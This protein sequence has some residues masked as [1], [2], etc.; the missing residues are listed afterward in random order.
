METDCRCRH[1]TVEEAL[2]HAV[3]N[4]GQ[5]L[6]EP[7]FGTKTNRMANAGQ[8]IGFQSVDQRTRV[9]L[10]FDPVKGLHVNEEDFSRP[11]HLQKVVHRV[12]AVAEPMDEA[13]RQTLLNWQENRM[14]LY[15]H[16][17][18]KRY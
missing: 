4:V 18:T 3:S 13:A 9:R 10:D 17:W 14:L 7:M 12:E 15:W 5:R 1:L 6:T 8:V 11:I 2:K 16:K